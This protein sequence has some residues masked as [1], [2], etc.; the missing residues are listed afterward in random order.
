LFEEETGVPS[1]KRG[2]GATRGRAGLKG[3]RPRGAS[4]TPVVR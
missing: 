4:A 2:L 1:K 3:A